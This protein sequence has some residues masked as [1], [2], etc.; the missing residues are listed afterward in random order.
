MHDDSDNEVY[1]IETLIDGQWKAT[2][3]TGLTPEAAERKLDDWQKMLPERKFRVR[4]YRAVI[5]GFLMLAFGLASMG[6]GLSG[7]AAE[8]NR[9]MAAPGYYEQQQ[10]RATEGPPDGY[11]NWQNQLQRKKERGR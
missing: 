2:I 7:W 1:L 10:L 8:V 6:A 3:G 9:G 11:D 5:G 4:K